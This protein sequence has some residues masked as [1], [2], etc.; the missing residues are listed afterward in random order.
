MLYTVEQL[1]LVIHPTNIT[2]T[3]CTCLSFSVCVCLFVLVRYAIFFWISISSL[4]ISNICVFIRFFRF[5]I[6]KCGC[7]FVLLPILLFYFHQE[8][9]DVH[10]L[11][12]II[13]TYAF[14]IFFL[15]TF[16]SLFIHSLFFFSLSKRKL[17]RASEEIYAFYQFRYLTG[18]YWTFLQF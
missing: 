8:L 5:V 6:F 10:W 14:C 7:F 2:S 16:S 12:F 9:S 1:Y 18:K 13:N 15:P 11:S 4:F 3:Y 17:K